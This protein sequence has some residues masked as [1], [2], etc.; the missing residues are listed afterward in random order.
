MNFKFL[1]P[2]IYLLC[3]ATNSAFA[4][5]D[6]VDTL[7]VIKKQSKEQVA[8]RDSIQKANQVSVD[9]QKGTDQK[10][11]QSKIIAS[12]DSSR[13]VKRKIKTRDSYAGTKIPFTVNRA[14]FGIYTDYINDYIDNYRNNHGSRLSRIQS[15]NK[16]YFKLI[17]NVMKRNSLPRELRALAIIES[18]L[19]CNAVSPVG[20]VGTWQFMEGTAK[21]MGLR[22]DEEVDERRDIYKSTNAAA[23]YLKKLH[24]MF[25]DWLLVIASYNCGP[26]P[27]LRAI[28]SGNGKSFWDIKPKLPRE[29]QNHVMAFI[30]TNAF[31]DKYTSVLTMGEAPKPN[32]KI[33][34]E[35]LKSSKK[36][37]LNS[38]E[39]K[40]AQLNKIS[41]TL[42]NN[43]PEESVADDVVV[44]LAKP[45]FSKEELD[46]MAILKVKGNYNLNTISRL[47]DEDLVRLKRWNPTFDAD[48]VNASAPIH[49]RLPIAKIEKFIIERDNIIAAS[50]H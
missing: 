11:V 22:V 25:H 27:V 28:N 13:F 46:I 20:A 9:N 23:R 19:N 44:E 36:I 48:I 39:S 18:A 33:K 45:T 17:D 3:C 29:T 37:A 42:V 4:Q 35:S 2:S 1:I 38:K 7:I 24:N 12:V 5:R 30:A 34:V 8:K 10:T 40:V 50:K 16:A 47:L 14:V 6:H 41:S 15:N 31:L 21:M 32:S 26:A 49:L 43:E